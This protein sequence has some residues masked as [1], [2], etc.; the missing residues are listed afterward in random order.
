MRLNNAGKWA[1][2]QLTEDA[3]FGKEI[4]FSDEA[5]LGG[6]VNKQNCRIWGTENPQ[7]YIEKPT[8]PKRVTVWCWFWSRGIIGPFFLWKWARRGRYSQ[9]RSLSGHVVVN[10]RV[11]SWQHLV[12]KIALS[13]TELMSFGHLGA[14]IWH[15]WSIICGV[16]W[17]ISVTSKSQR[18]LKL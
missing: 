4:I 14:E 2:D 11:G 13:A 9:W 1:C 8:H 12:F 7:A 15:R 6:Y 5:D 18:Q 17:K 3:D 10:W 16:P